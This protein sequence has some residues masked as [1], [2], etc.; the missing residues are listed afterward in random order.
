MICINNSIKTFL[1]IDPDR[2]ASEWLRAYAKQI[3]SVHQD[4]P[5]F[6]A[7]LGEAITRG[8]HCV[9]EITKE[10]SPMLYGLICRIDEDTPTIRLNDTEL[11]VSD[12][13][14]LHV[15]INHSLELTQELMDLFTVVSFELGEEAID[16]E[17]RMELLKKFY[18]EM[19]ARQPEIIKRKVALK[20]ELNNQQKALVGMFHS[21]F[22]GSTV[23][24]KT[25]KD[26]ESIKH[27]VVDLTRNIK[28]QSDLLEQYKL[29]G[30]VHRM[31]SVAHIFRQAMEVIEKNQPG[32]YLRRWTKIPSYVAVLKEAVNLPTVT[33]EKS[34]LLHLYFLLVGS[35]SQTERELFA[36]LIMLKMANCS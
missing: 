5:N 27:R 20:N 34:L 7:I 1:M 13:F 30:L 9:V 10:M 17:M 29:P 24:E 35:L 6:A 19:L 25:V 33:D 21:Q 4:D 23:S 32:E 8:G 18:P 14:K 22:R 15:S 28:D 31:I 26:F 36:V 3:K 11:T 16:R 12:E 2:K